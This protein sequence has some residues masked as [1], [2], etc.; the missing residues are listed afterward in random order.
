MGRAE[1]PC[2]EKTGC[3]IKFDR[4]NYLFFNSFTLHR[5]LIPAPKLTIVACGQFLEVEDTE[6]R[7]MQGRLRGHILSLIPV[8]RGA[9]FCFKGGLGSRRS[10]GRMMR[11][12]SY[13]TSIRLCQLRAPRPF[14]RVKDSAEVLL[15]RP[16]SGPDSLTFGGSAVIA[17]SRGEM[18]EIGRNGDVYKT[19][20]ENEESASV[21]WQRLRGEQVLCF[22]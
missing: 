9:I 5:F 17:P 4:Q 6:R 10:Q 20:G 8:Q 18:G 12:Q 19:P 16:L 2:E 22:H 7:C 11:Q 21:L 15:D 1:D 13:R 3:Q 14:G